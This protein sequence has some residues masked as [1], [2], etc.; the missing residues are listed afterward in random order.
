MQNI[1]QYPQAEPTRAPCVMRPRTGMT[2][3]ELLI[4]L[5]ISAILLAVGVP[6]FNATIAGSKTA[7]AASDLRGALELARSE[8]IRRGVTVSICRVTA[9]NATPP[10][11]SNAAA[12]IFAAGDWASGWVVFVED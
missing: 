12:G 1:E 7:G 10:V 11:C 6:M 2:L 4:V 3:I 8:A 9:P 5:A